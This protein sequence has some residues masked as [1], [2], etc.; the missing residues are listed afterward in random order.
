MDDYKHKEVLHKEL[1]LQ[2]LHK[3]VTLTNYFLK[4]KFEGIRSRW[5][6]FIQF[7][8]GLYYKYVCQ[9]YSS[10]L[11]VNNFPFCHLYFFSAVLCTPMPF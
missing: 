5:L 6:H 1:Q 10:P 7:M 4:I 9:V 3:E 11:T 2:R 8:L